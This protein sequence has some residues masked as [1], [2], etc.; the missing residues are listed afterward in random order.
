MSTLSKSEL[1]DVLTLATKFNNEH[2]A[3]TFAG[4][5]IPDAV[6][7][8][9]AADYKALSISETTTYAKG[10]VLR[11]FAN[12]SVPLVLEALATPVAE[13]PAAEETV[14]TPTKVKKVK[15]EEKEEPVVE[16]PPEEKPVV[17]GE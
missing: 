3:L 14:T 7:K 10:F 1:F 12:R 16:S 5:E 11:D 13:K 4:T 17:E 6:H 15:V 8:K 9:L 2:T